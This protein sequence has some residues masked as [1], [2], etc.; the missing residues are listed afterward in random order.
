MISNKFVLFNLKF[1]PY[2]YIY[3]VY[4]HSLADIISYHNGCVESSDQ[5]ISVVH[6]WAVFQF[7]YVD[8]GFKKYSLHRF[9]QNTTALAEQGSIYKH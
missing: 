7:L 1:S 3:T 2:I 8:L 9:W 4:K 5:G 6:S